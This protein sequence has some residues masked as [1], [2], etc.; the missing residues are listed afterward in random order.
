MYPPF[1]QP[2][3]LGDQYFAAHLDEGKVEVAN[4]V[5]AFADEAFVLIS[6]EVKKR[7]AVL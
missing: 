5:D 1:G 6:F 3:F 2:L 7:V 4:V